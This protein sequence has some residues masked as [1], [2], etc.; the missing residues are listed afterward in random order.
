MNDA[1]G[2]N[3]SE[4]ITYEIEKTD[5]GSNSYVLTMCVD[6]AYLSSVD[7]QYPVVIDPSYTWNSDPSLYDVYVLSGH[8]SSNYYSSGVTGMYAGKTNAN[9]IE[10]TYMFFS[11]LQS[12]VNGCSVSSASLTL[13]EISGGTSGETVQVYRVSGPWSKSNLNWNNKPGYGT[14]VN[15]CQYTATLHKAVNIDITSYARNVANGSDHYGIMLKTQNE[16]TS[17]YAK[18][19]GTRHSSTQYRPKVVVNYC[20]KPTAATTVS[21]SNQYIKTGSSVVAAWSGISSSALS[22]VQY[23]IASLNADGTSVVNAS[24]VPYS[25]STKIGTA[26]SGSAEINTSLLTEGYYNIYIRGVD[27]YGSAGEE[28]SIRIYMDGTAPMIGNVSLTP[29]GTS[30]IPASDAQPV[31]SW[32]NVSDRF[33]KQVEYSVNGGSYTEMGTTSSG[34]FDLPEGVIT[35]TGTYT[36]RVRA[37]DEAG[38]LSSV[39]TLTYYYSASKPEIGRFLI[40][41]DADGVQFQLMDLTENDEVFQG[42]DV[43]WAVV[44]H[45]ESPS[46]ADYTE[47]IGNSQ[48]GKIHFTV[49]ELSVDSGIYDVYVKVLNEN[50]SVSEP[51]MAVLYYF[52]NAVYNGTLNLSAESLSEDQEKSSTWKLTWD[53]ESD[54]GTDAGRM[55]SAD[56]Y[57]SLDGGL[58][59]KETTVTSGQIELNFADVDSYAM[60]RIIGNYADGSHKLS[61]IIAMEK[62]TEEE[63]ISDAE[64]ELANALGEEEAASMESGEILEIAQMDA[65]AISSETDQGET[66]VFYYRQ[67]AKDSDQDGLEDGYEI[68]DFGTAADMM[69]TDGDGFPD[70]YEIVL[71]GT[72]PVVYT[73]DKDSDN[74]GLSNLQEL[75]ENTDPYLS[76]TDFDGILDAA[77]TEPLKTDTA[78]GE[79]VNYNV[80]VNKGLY[81]LE[82]SGTIYN[83]YSGLTKKTARSDT[84]YTLRY[85]DKKDNQTAELTKADSKNYLNT[86][87]WNAGGQKIYMTY[88]GLPYVYT[89]DSLDN[90]LTVSVN[91]TRL[92]QYVYGYDYEEDEETGGSYKS[93]SYLTRVNYANGG[94]IRYL[95]E[96]MDILVMK[97]DEDGNITTETKREHKLAYIK[98]DGKATDSSSYT[99]NQYGNVTEYIDSDSG[100]TYT[101]SYDNKQNLTGITGNNGFSMGTSSTDNSNRDA[102]EISYTT[103][104]VWNL[105]EVQKTVHYSYQS[106]EPSK[107]ETAE[108]DLLTGKKLTVQRNL[109]TGNSTTAIGSNISWTTTE[110]EN[111]GTIVYRDGNRL[112]YTYDSNGNITQISKKASA[113]AT[114]EILATYVY[115]GMNQLIRE[116][117]CHSNTTTVYTYDTNGNLIGSKIYAYTAGNVSGTASATHTWNYTDTNWRDLLT[118][119]DGTAITYDAGGN[120]LTWKNGGT[121]TWQGGRQ[122][123]QYEDSTQT[124]GYT[125]NDSGIRTKKTITDKSTGT[126]VTK[127]YYLDESNILAEKVSGSGNADRTVWYSYS[128]DGTLAGFM[129]N[130]A[131]YYYQKNLQGDIVGIYNAAGELVVTYEYDAWGNLT[132][133]TDTSGNNLGEINPFRYRGYYYDED[134]GWYYLQSRYYDAEVGRF[135]NADDVE[136]LGNEALGC[137]LFTYCENEPVNHMDFNGCISISIILSGTFGLVS[138][139][140][141][142]LA[143]KEVVTGAKKFT[144]VSLIL[145]SIG[146]ISAVKSFY[147]DYNKY[148]KSNTSYGKKQLRIA[149]ASFALTAVSFVFSIVIAKINPRAGKYISSL[150][151]VIGTALGLT[152]GIISI[153]T[154][155]TKA[156]NKSSYKNN[157]KIVAKYC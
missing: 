21:L 113:D 41:D 57:V 27:Q 75:E 121:L 77:D 56:V 91:G 53:T 52:P 16:T 13:Y 70:R 87:T 68:W 92:V 122:L 105:G 19:Y 150:F 88:N 33:L 1:S 93:D 63:A 154:T 9:G 84:D 81:D 107:M 43:L 124:I 15:S 23:R 42:T 151:F 46:T 153:L 109:E 25:S 35:T 125:Y 37:R 140:I 127:T 64:S 117:N 26:S 67:I 130:N 40:S 144:V 145:G 59:A 7:T 54:S 116:N 3:Y 69:D 90:I 34:S 85:Y 96:D 58:F 128:G 135:L 78:S 47:A 104:T 112:L 89:Y 71:L 82:E 4:A 149:K 60:Y 6:Q 74:D 66:T 136:Y 17:K 108:T 137:N 76:D 49:D 51:A 22:Y 126:T 8:A 131:D 65:V 14:L 62:V 24:V 95:Y 101:Y 152:S 103:D 83:P 132:D 120:P 119:Y 148:K 86:Y 61:D 2:E 45:G 94:N 118:S 48:S 79:T 11:G 134:T 98:V 28:K 129:Y 12:M 80:S 5:E 32:S 100:V 73:A 139:I 97:E 30:A 110:G 133:M 31:I 39:K 138:Y 99:Y 38:N 20:A 115:D 157:K 102:G 106:S 142:W 143:L 141:S 36:I 72:N 44:E 156:L 29:S 123:K 155:M 18:Y 55:T 114:E 147:S 146:F 111:Q 10:R 50:G